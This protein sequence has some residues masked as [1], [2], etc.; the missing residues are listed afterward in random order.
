L[1]DFDFSSDVSSSSEED[2]KPKSKKG[3]F[4]G[5]CLMGK[6]S[7]NISDFDSNVND[8]PSPESVSLNGKLFHAIKENNEL[9]QEVAYLT[10]RLEKM[11]LSEKMIDKDLSR[12]EKSATKAT[13]K[14]GVGFEMCEDKG[15]KSA[16]KF[17]P[18]STYHKEE[19]TIKSTKTH[20]PSNAKSSFN[21]K[22]EVRK[23]TPKLREK[24]FVCMFCGRDGHL[25]EFFFRRKR[26]EKRSFEYVRNSY[27]DEFFDFP[28]HSY[29][30]D[31]THTSYRAL[32]HFSHRP[33]HRS[34]GFGS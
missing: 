30:R 9:Q 20:Y 5:L 34:Y 14:L 3:D 7:R 8:D 4:T 23:E 19:A 24:A 1:S 13:Y 11:V 32:S 17:I 10:A 6:S 26:I 29:S 18:S 12:V 15:K 2:E 28:P 27:H 21:P 25:D 33:N 31:L 16:P 22:R